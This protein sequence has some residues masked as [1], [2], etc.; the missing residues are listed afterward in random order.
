M[1]QSVRTFLMVAVG[2]VVGGLVLFGL[3]ALTGVVDL[4]GGGGDEVVIEADSPEE[5]EKAV[6]QAIDESL[7]EDKNDPSAIADKW[8]E[9]EEGDQMKQLGSATIDID[10]KPA[11]MKRLGDTMLAVAEDAPPG[12]FCADE[13]IDTVI[14]YWNNSAS[15]KAAQKFEPREE[16]KRLRA[17][18]RERQLDKVF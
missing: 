10:I 7:E 13:E 9:S 16:V 1:S 15:E 17:F 5:A 2:V 8:C 14:Q 18:V 12:A 11:R 6:D 4:G 3:G